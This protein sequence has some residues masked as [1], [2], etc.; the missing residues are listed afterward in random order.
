MQ[1]FEI[2]LT[3]SKNK[4]KF[5]ENHKAINKKLQCIIKCNESVIV[6][7]SQKQLP[8]SFTYETGL[9]FIREIVDIV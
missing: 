9:N 7:I 1:S 2:I 4:L 8:N 3:F 6:P 5:L